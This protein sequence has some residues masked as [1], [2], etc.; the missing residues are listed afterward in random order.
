MIPPVLHQTWKSQRIPGWATKWHASWYKYNP[1]LQLVLWSDKMN[2]E[3]VKTYAPWFL[4]TYDAF[5]VHIQRVDAVRY[6]ILYLYGGIYVD[7]DFECYK[8]IERFRQYDL[9]FSYSGNAP[10]ITNSIMMSRPGHPFWLKVLRQMQKMPPKKWY[11]L[12]SYY[13]LRTTGPVMLH[14]VIQKYNFS[15]DRI[16]VLRSK[17]FFPFSMFEKHKRDHYFPQAYGAHHHMCTWT[18]DHQMLKGLALVL[19]VVISLLIVWRVMAFC[20][21]K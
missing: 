14:R 20:A 1:Q 6:L 17:Y 11:E 10:F 7:L 16:L 19:V 13:V 2:R 12:K 9:V 15:K 4:K 3:L 18:N 8:S 5:P 21:V